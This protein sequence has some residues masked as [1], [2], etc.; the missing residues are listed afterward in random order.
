MIEQQ[1]QYIY[2]SEEYFYIYLH[3][4]IGQGAKEYF[5]ISIPHNSSDRVKKQNNMRKFPMIVKHHLSRSFKLV[6]NSDFLLDN[7]HE[8]MFKSNY[9]F[10]YHCRLNEDL[11]ISELSIPFISFTDLHKQNTQ[12]IYKSEF[13]YDKN[14]IISPTIL[15]YLSIRSETIPIKEF[16]ET[17]NQSY[18]KNL[19]LLNL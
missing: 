6:L 14:S 8:D 17:I 12:I 16:V 9:G 19:L 15:S 18:E 11:T 5:N 4:L 3:I 7:K 1:K 13:V 10:N 2:F